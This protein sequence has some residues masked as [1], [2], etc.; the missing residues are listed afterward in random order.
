VKEQDYIRVTT[1]AKLRIAYDILG[2]IVPEHARAGEKEWRGMLA[3]L[4]D[5]IR[6][7][8]PKG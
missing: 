4:S 2:D 3:M 7:L 8:E 1:L 5:S 6:R